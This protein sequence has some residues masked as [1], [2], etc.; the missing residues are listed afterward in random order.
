MYIYHP[1]SLRYVMYR[2]IRVSAFCPVT[3]IC[4]SL[5]ATPLSTKGFREW[6]L[7]GYTLCP[8]GRSSAYIYIYVYIYTYIYI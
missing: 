6:L 3:S 8:Y 4:T 2:D 1:V 7:R 5:P